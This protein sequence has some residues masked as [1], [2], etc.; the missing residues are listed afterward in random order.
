MCP[1]ACFPEALF[2]L[3]SVDLSI[4]STD[5]GILKRRAACDLAFV[6]RFCKGLAYGMWSV[7][8]GLIIHKAFC[9]NWE[10]RKGLSLTY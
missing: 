10:R 7:N 2:T 8:D 4:A 9:T 3:L 5:L 6:S 1:C